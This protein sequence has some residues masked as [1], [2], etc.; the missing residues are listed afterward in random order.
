MPDLDLGDVAIHYE[1]LGSGPLAYVFCHG[2]GGSGDAFLEHF[3]FSRQHFPRVVTWDARGL[4]RSSRADKYSMPL[5]ASDLARLLDKLGVRKAVLHGVSW[6]GLLVR[7][8][9]AAVRPGVW[10]QR[11]GHRHRL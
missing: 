4:G 10:G 9:G 1:E 2:L 7:S 3:A 11:P 5:Y 8:L 6:G